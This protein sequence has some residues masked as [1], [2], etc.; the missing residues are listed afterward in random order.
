MEMA[1][2]LMMNAMTVIKM[3]E[4]AVLLYA[5]SRMGFSVRVAAILLPTSAHLSTQASDL[6]LSDLLHMDLSTQ[7]LESSLISS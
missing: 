4:M 6:S 3:M 7:A 2:G 1:V 5:K